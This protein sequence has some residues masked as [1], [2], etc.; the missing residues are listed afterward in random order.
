MLNIIGISMVILG[1]VG[2][3]ISVLLAFIWRVPDLLDELSGRKAKRQIKHLKEINIGTGGME[4]IRTNELYGILNSGNLVWSSL[5]ISKDSREDLEEADESVEKD[6]NVEK[7]YSLSP[8]EGIPKVQSVFEEVKVTDDDAIIIDPYADKEM[9]K[10][11]TSELKLGKRVNNRVIIIQE[12]SS[13][14]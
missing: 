13:I 9:E 6:E 1:V 4:S 3:F 10:I 8:L 14:F 5:E 7:R 11:S 12:E 2:L